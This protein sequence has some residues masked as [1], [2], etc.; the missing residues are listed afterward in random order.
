MRMYCVCDL[1]TLQKPE[2]G[3]NVDEVMK[4]LLENDSDYKLND[5]MQGMSTDEHE[6]PETDQS[7]I[8]V[9]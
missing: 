7:F 9:M 5:V 3:L 6:A 1:Y 2:L 8:T 4:D